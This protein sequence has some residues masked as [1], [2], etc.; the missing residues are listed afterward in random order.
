MISGLNRFSFRFQP[1]S[2]LST[3]RDVGRPTPPKTRFVAQD[4][5]GYF[6]SPGVKKKGNWRS[7]PKAL[8]W[9]LTPSFLLREATKYVTS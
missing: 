8:T 1:A 5:Q 3:L 7:L 6:A 9:G 4:I 2:L